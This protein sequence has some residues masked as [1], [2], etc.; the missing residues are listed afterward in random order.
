MLGAYARGDHASARR[1]ALRLSACASC[2]AQIA[3]A[4]RLLR[5]TEPDGFL[6]VMGALGLGLV[7]WLVY[8]YVW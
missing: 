3:E 2:P 6:P 4:R 1:S 7:G 5:L 8:N